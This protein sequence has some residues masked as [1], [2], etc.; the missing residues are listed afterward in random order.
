MNCPFCG[1]NL[2]DGTDFCSNCGQVITPTQ[3][4]NPSGF[5]PNAAIFNG[6]S[7]NAPYQAS[8]AVPAKKSNGAVIGAI[9]AVLVVVGVVLFI[10]TNC[11]YIGN[12]S[13]Y[14]I[15]MTYMG[16]EMTFTADE[17]GMSSEDA[18]LSVGLFNKAS[19]TFE[20]KKYTGKLKVKG[21]DVEIIGSDGTLDGIF[22]KDE[23]TI[24]IILP[25]DELM[26][27]LSSEEAAMMSYFEDFQLIFKK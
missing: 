8:P 3:S 27:S 13:F 7:N 10:L 20:G 26:A 19:F 5:N 2:P 16:Q 12:Y 24:S 25:K 18:K 22:D 11:K 15:K 17:L 1:A 23:K 6:V 4:S 9:V 14:G 21:K